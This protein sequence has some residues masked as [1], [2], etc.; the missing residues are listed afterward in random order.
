MKSPTLLETGLR[1][2]T[3]FSLRE[4]RGMVICGKPFTIRTS[5]ITTR[6]GALAARPEQGRSNS[7]AGGKRGWDREEAGKG[8]SGGMGRVWL[9]R[10]A[11]RESPRKKRLHRAM[12]QRRG[13][14]R[15]EEKKSVHFILL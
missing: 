9:W 3:H 7:V 14:V 4:G 5:S 10:G 8:R 1:E 2:K 15:V 11:Q 13:S 6:G 12:L